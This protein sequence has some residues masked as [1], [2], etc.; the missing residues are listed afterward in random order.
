[1]SLPRAAGAVRFRSR[2][3]VESEGD[4]EPGCVVDTVTGAP[5]ALR[6]AVGGAQGKGASL[7]RSET[8]LS[9]EWGF[10]GIF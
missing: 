8:G 10:G 6:S 2:F 3:V 7:L 1:M 4:P 9:M 5:R